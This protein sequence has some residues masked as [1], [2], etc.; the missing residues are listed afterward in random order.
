MKL[1]KEMIKIKSKKTTLGII[2]VIL[3]IL[4]ILSNLNVIDLNLYRVVSNIIEGLFD[5]WPLILVVIGISIIFKKEALNTI[6]W[7]VFLVI[8]IIYSL[9]MKNDIR[10]Q[11]LSN[12]NFSEQ[13]FKEETYSGEMNSSI[14]RGRLDLD[15]GATS[16]KIESIEDDFMKL[17]H[18]GAFNYKISKEGRTEN[19]YISNKKNIIQNGMDRRLKLGLN[20]T[21]PWI[22]DLDMGAASGNLDLKDIMVEEFDLDMGAGKIEASFGNKAELTIID[23]DSG[24]SQII[25]NIPKDSGL[26]INMDGA[27]N[28][29][30]LDELG[31]MKIDKG[32]YISN[33]FNSTESKFEIE[34]DMGVGN[35]EIN[36]Y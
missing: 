2:L 22:I 13:S 34:V 7:I 14:E 36:F 10:Q 1:I 23:I 12:K 6:L 32:E 15:I 28:S 26:K 8:L 9:F 30:N 17:D 35:F 24:A 25:L 31:L 29:T 4:W 11:E 16:F 18:D 33:N 20:K 19:I 21:I 5:L 27:L 3:G